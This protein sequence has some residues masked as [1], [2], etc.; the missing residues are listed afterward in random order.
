MT[1]LY[2]DFATFNEYEYVTNVLTTPEFITE[3]QK[4]AIVV[5]VECWKFDGRTEKDL[6]VLYFDNIDDAKKVKFGYRSDIRKH[7]EPIHIY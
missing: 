6:K 4:Y 3:K 7:I 5:E 1:T 2:C